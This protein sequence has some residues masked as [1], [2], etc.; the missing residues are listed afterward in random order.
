MKPFGE[1]KKKKSHLFQNDVDVTSNK[2]RN[3]LPFSGLHRVVALLVLPK[4]LQTDRFSLSDELTML[5]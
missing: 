1:K 2:L 3:L 5:Q 4:V